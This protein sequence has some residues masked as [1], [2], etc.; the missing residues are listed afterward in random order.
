MSNKNIIWISGG[1]TGIGRATAKKFIREGWVVIVTARNQENL[2]SLKEEIKNSY[3]FENLHIFNC[4]NRNIDQIDK[5]L[6]EIEKNIGF[7]DIALLNAGTTHPYSEDFNLDYYNHV[8]N[9]NIIG[10][11]NCINSIYPKFKERKKGHLSIVSS[12]VGFRGLPTASAYT[13]S[14]AALINLAE[15][16][17]FDFKKIGVRVSLI[18]PGFIKTP[19]TNKN[20]FPM[21]FLKSSEYAAKKIYNGIIRTNKFEIIFPIQWF[22]IMKFLRLLPYKIYFYL[23]KK[24]TGL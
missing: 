6:I 17:Y 16:L 7:I 8:I 21:P 2:I 11:L 1:S 5:T 24:A 15:S 23:V 10:T 3:N 13:M 9:T 12:M 22:I 14:K 20:K 18:N 19:L 4:D